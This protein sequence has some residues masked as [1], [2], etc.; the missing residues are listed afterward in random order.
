MRN[1]ADQ[2]VT[3]ELEPTQSGFAP[4]AP[5]ANVDLPKHASGQV[6]L[7][8]VGVAFGFEGVGNSKGQLTDAADGSGREMVIYPNTQTDTDTAITYT[9]SGVETFNYLRSAASP[10][11]FSLDYDLPSG[12]DIVATDDGGAVVLDSE[13]QELVTVFTP[14]AVDAQGT[15]VPMTL[16]V[17]AE[18]IVLGVPHQG[19][20]FA[21]PI[22]V[23]PVQHVRDWWTN[24]ST[25]GFE[26]WTFLQSGTTNYNSSLSCPASLVSIDPCGGTGSGVYVSSVPGSYYPA[27][28]MGYWRWSVPGGSSSSITGATIS[29][30]RYRK[31][32]TNP[33]WGF[34][35]LWDSTSGYSFTDGGGGS[36]LSL[37]GANSGVKYLHSG[38]ATSTANTIPTGAT[39]RRYMRIAGY[40]ATMTDGEPPTITVSGAPTGWLKDNADFTVTANAADPGLGLGWIQA[41][42]GGAW[43][44]YWIGWCTGTYG[45]ECPKNASPTMTFNTSD[46]PSGVNDVYTRAID[47]VAGTGHETI[48]GFNLKVDKTKPTLATSGSLFDDRKPG[49]ELIVQVRDNTL[50]TPVY[51]SNGDLNMTIPAADYSKLGSGAK[52]VKLTVDG[53][54]VAFVERPACANAN[55]SCRIG[56]LLL[57]LDLSLLS[58]GSHPLVLS[59]KDQ[60]GN[61]AIPIEW[62]KVIDRTGPTVSNPGLTSDWIAADSANLNIQA[63]DSGYGVQKMVAR[64]NGTPIGNK[65]YSCGTPSTSA[66]DPSVSDTI[67]LNLTSLPDGAHEVSITAEDPGGHVGAPITK[68]IF[69]DRETAEIDAVEVPEWLPTEGL[70]Q[71][72][73]SN[74]GSGIESATLL[75]NGVEVAEVTNDCSTGCPARIVGSTSIDANGVTG[76]TNAA[77]DLEIVVTTPVPA[78]STTEERDAR[79]DRDSPTGLISGAVFESSANPFGATN[80]V[81]VD[82][83]DQG[84]G[85]ALVRL[86]LDGELVDEIDAAEIENVDAP[87]SNGA[88]LF[89]GVVD[90]VV[91]GV[92]EPGD[93]EL[94]VRVLDAAGNSFSRLAEVELDPSLPSI[95]L[96]GDLASSH[97]A[98]PSNGTSEIEVRARDNVNVDDTGLIRVVLKVDGTVVA[99][100]CESEPCES[101]PNEVLVP[102]EFDEGDWANPPFELEATAVD[103]AGNVTSAGLLVD[104]PTIDPALSN[105]PS[106]ES[107]YEGSNLSDPDATLDSISEIA[108]EVTEETQ[109]FEYGADSVSSPELVQRP[110]E[111]GYAVV[112]TP[113]AGAVD[114]GGQGVVDLGRGICISPTLWNENATASQVGDDAILT[115]NSRPGTSTFVQPGYNGATVV[116]YVETPSALE[117]VSWMPQM[118][119]GQEATLLPSGDVA[120]VDTTRPTNARLAEEVDESGQPSDAQI[121]ESLASTE[122]QS[123]VSD[124][125]ILDA[126]LSSP[127]SVEAVISKPAVLDANGDPVNATVSVSDTVE[128]TYDVP[129]QT[130]FPILI[131]TQGFRTV[132]PKALCEDAFALHALARAEICG[133]MS[134]DPLPDNPDPFTVPAY[135]ST[136]YN[137]EVTDEQMLAE[138]GWDQATPSA[139]YGFG[140]LRF[141]RFTVG[142]VCGR[143]G[144]H[145]CDLFAN[146]ALQAVVWRALLYKNAMAPRYS[147][148]DST[149]ANAYQ[150]TV[151]TAMMAKT[152]IGQGYTG[153]WGWRFSVG[154][155]KGGDLSGDPFVRKSAKMDIIND[156]VGFFIGRSNHNDSEEDLCQIA[157]KRSWL[158][159]F[160]KRKPEPRLVT[161][162]KMI[163]RLNR[164][165]N[166]EGDVVTP[167]RSKQCP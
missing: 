83:S 10:E 89:D 18:K 7:S 33:G 141:N 60:V 140:G 61:D 27:G 118:E 143:V 91:G 78:R 126:M 110:S 8:D 30:W 64:V 12:A 54:Q 101:T 112:G 46:F 123:D 69:V 29:S 155:E 106:P 25:P 32:N 96:V 47:I 53:T 133:P 79:I 108:P 107:V 45:A 117:G 52:S 21:Y 44:N 58:E 88:C 114:I 111:E 94:T 148:A 85:L 59:G 151:W 160:I 167:N 4:K 163:Y 31:G 119:E 6:E 120:I 158:A 71:I 17:D 134:D 56:P 20:D 132:D 146:D 125:K 81:E 102:Y 147:D 103:A 113:D 131:V 3:G 77:V 72:D 154:Y 73:A 24:G 75:A 99:S 153:V 68:T 63:V 42:Y 128:L 70:F 50:S 161:K 40:S 22:M 164:N 67:P 48:G 57:D 144:K 13:G 152:A 115:E 93:Y 159:K 165:R 41:L 5:H 124:M 84:S 34:I 129:P 65:T 19:E 109:P 105:C 38:L 97:G 28:S 80:Q 162:N 136:V 15:L 11:T 26:G 149:V 74:A 49:N 82:G 16:S 135:E 130:A 14:Y 98:L 87:C 51:H 156:Y 104:L 55:G 150:H 139:V 137:T 76:T 116:E 166:G 142:E 92:Y 138:L 1:D 43:T 121:I 95:E 100:S 2:I 157:F 39:N 36:G 127:D 66:C 35:N 122:T 62:T 37:V 145:T 23:D 86:L 90:T 9:L